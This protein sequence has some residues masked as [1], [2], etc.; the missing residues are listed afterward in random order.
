MRH[1]VGNSRWSPLPAPEPWGRLSSSLPFLESGKGVHS[2]PGGESDFETDPLAT[3]VTT[4]TIPDGALVE[5]PG[6]GG[7]GEAFPLPA[8]PNKRERVHSGPGREFDF[9]TDPLPTCATT[10]NHP[11]AYS[12][13]RSVSRSGAGAGA[14]ACPTDGTLGRSF[15]PPCPSA[16]GGRELHP[17]WK[18]KPEFKRTRDQGAGA[19]RADRGGHA[20][21]DPRRRVWPRLNAAQGASLRRPAA[22]ARSG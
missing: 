20:R 18:P 1:D 4:W 11:R 2:D 9:E 8:L 13:R 16:G 7:C 14:A 21:P 15:P 10:W 3:W 19:S 17:A 12:D 5:P 22:S 6:H